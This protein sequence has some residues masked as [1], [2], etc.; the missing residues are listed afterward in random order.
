MAKVDQP[1]LEQDLLF[2]N[3]L[4]VL[5]EEVLMAPA[6][7]LGVKTEVSVDIAAEDLVDIQHPAEVVIGLDH[8]D[9]LVPEQGGI[10]GVV[11]IPRR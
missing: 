5:P 1:V 10:Q 3:T 11:E 4:L 7:L 9:D 6:V 8:L 2:L